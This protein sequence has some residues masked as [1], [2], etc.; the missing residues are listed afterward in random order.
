M[1]YERMTQ[2]FPKP[3]TSINQEANDHLEDNAKGGKTQWKTEQEMPN[4]CSVK[5]DT[6]LIQ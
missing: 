2:E 4:P 3:F 5:E 6:L 1:S